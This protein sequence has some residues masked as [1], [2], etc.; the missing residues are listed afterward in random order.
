MSE[1]TMNGRLVALV[2]AF[3]IVAGLLA[4]GAPL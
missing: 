2:V 4:A 1:T 3:A